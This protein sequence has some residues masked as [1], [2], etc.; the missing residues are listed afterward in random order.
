[1]KL[2]PLTEAHLDAAA[3][4]W[5]RG[6]HDGHADV[7]PEGLTRLR[8]LENFRERLVA[9]RAATTLAIADGAVRGLFMLEGN[10]L[11]QFYV[12][13]DARGT[14]L[15]QWLMPQAEA[16]LRGAGHDRVWLACSVGNARAARFY[17]KAG[18]SFVRIETFEAETS[19]GPFPLDI[20]RYEKDL[21]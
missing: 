5:C 19:A 14:G 16:A 10:E 2:E 9:H 12:H 3:E 17:E 1:M 4:M 8:T 13:P 20:W 11:E 21:S 15:A 6:W 18:W 7:V